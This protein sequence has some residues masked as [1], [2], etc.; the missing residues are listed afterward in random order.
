[1]FPEG[2]RF[3]GNIIDEYMPRPVLIWR[4]GGA[5]FRFE[6]HFNEVKSTPLRVSTLR[7]TR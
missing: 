1:M 4:A 7:Q 3:A 5:P 6:G 2:H